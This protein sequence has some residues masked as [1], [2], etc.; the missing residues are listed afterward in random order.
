MKKIFGL[1]FFLH[2]LSFALAQKDNLD[3]FINQAITNSPLLKDYQSQQ[4]S[5]SLD[6]QLIRAALRPQVNG[7][8][9][10][11]YAPTIRGWG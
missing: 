11:Y 3:Y 5:L 8:S 6:S 4:L 7:N 2:I 1:F 9:N 10:N